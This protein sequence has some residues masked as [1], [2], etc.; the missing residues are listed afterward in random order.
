[1]RRFP[2][3]F[4]MLGLCCSA[5]AGATTDCGAP[6][7]FSCP[8]AAEL[9]QAERTF[10]R[11]GKLSHKGLT[12]EALE[13]FEAAARLVPYNRQYAL[14]RELGRQQAAYEHLRRGNRKLMERRQV[15]ALAE[16]RQALELDPANQ[17]AA[18]RMRDALDPP[19]YAQNQPPAASFSTAAGAAARLKSVSESSEL[20]LQPQPGKRTLRFRGDSRELLDQ[21]A[22]LFGLAAFFD[23]SVASRRVRMEVENV[24]FFTAMKLAG[25]V[26]HT[27]WVPLSEKEMLVLAESQENRRL[28]EPMSARTFYLTDAASTQELNDFVSLLRIMFDIRFIAAQ[29]AQSSVVVRAPKPVLDAA[30]R[31]L[32]SLRGGRPQV[33]LDVQ[34]FEL[35]ATALRQAGIDLPLQFRIFNVA[36]EV[37]SLLGQ[38][39]IQSLINQLFS[40]GGI[41]QP[42]PA[43]IA[44]LL[45]QLQ[46]QGNSLVGQ[47]I[48]SFGGGITRTGIVIPAQS[49]KLNMNQSLVT[50]LEHAV[51]RAGQ[52]TPATLRS[53]TRFPILNASFAPIFN[54][55]ALSQVLQ[56]Q[57]FRPA[58]PSF[59]YEDLGLTLKA[60][61]RV[62]ANLDISLELELQIKAL[63]AETFNS[64]PVITN[65]EYKSTLTLKE[66][67][68]AVVLGA[69]SQS[70]TR[71]LR[72]LPGLGQVPLLGRAASTATRETAENQLMIVITP[73]VVRLPPH[74]PQTETWLPS[75]Q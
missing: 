54:S 74:P 23:E 11:A 41:N 47:S 42:S 24:D 15:E 20:E 58:F 53:G 25:R 50:S 60:Q 32:D 26:T 43:A 65:R 33:L 57:S 17:F 70:E 21:V 14:A 40:S 4:L 34:A 18:Q 29:P 39:G 13:L 64:V 28:Y 75:A 3:L 37:R 8:S 68:T 52:G 67:E 31:V 71:S 35:N 63:G 10:R 16:F 55:P 59:S 38:P 62:L 9:R 5:A 66:G 51:L 49:V 12:L 1:M 72:G 44:A 7:N 30:A 69:I 22:R 6:L 46:N 19:G 73:H 61:P 56:N 48:A 27:F 45:A 2:T 36:T